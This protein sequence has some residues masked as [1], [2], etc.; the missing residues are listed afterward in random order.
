MAIKLTNTV[1]PARLYHNYFVTIILMRPGMS[2]GRIFTSYIPNC[3]M[4]T[5]IQTKN[6]VGSDAEYRVFLQQNA[7][8]IIANM[9][10]ICATQGSEQGFFKGNNCG[11]NK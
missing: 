4:N 9:N 3:Q 2:D 7:T 1:A 11:S 5:N 10:S 8:Q 6:N